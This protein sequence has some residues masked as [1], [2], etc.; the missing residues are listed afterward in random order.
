MPRAFSS[1]TA[2]CSTV[3]VFRPR[4]SNFTRPAFSTYFMLNWVAG[5]VER[6]SR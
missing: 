3:S 1:S 6:G 4:K 2:R 5:S